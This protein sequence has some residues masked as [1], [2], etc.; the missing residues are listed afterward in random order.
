M[1]D[2]IIESR[3]LLLLVVTKF[4]EIWAPLIEEWEGISRRLGAVL[5]LQPA[6]AAFACFVF[7]AQRFSFDSIVQSSWVRDHWGTPIVTC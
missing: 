7:F 5:C 3:N 4:W 6:L 2:F 1:T